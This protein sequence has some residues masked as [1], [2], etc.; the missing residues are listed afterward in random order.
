MSCHAL[1]FQN[2]A[3][4]I[5]LLV[6][7]VICQYSRGFKIVNS[8]DGGPLDKIDDIRP[9][10]PALAVS[11]VVL[12]QR[13]PYSVNLSDIHVWRPICSF[14]SPPL[15]TVLR[16]RD[17]GPSVQAI[18]CTLQLLDFLAVSSESPYIQLYTHCPI[19]IFHD[20]DQSLVH[21]H[22]RR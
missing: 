10:P 17:S 20:I 21:S 18:W 16:V 6:S 7:H 8:D 4:L 22:D 13:P 14:K 2:N 5:I 9:S 15:V 19:R 3:V 12:R 1:S 11:L